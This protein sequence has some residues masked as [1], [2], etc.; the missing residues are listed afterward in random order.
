MGSAHAKCVGQLDTAVLTA[1]CD[2]DE[3]VCAEKSAEHSVPGFTEHTRLLDSGLVD[4]VLIATPHYFHPPIAIDAFERGIHVLSE[5]PIAVTV[6]A[7]DEMIA[8]ARKSGCKFA[9]MFQMRTEAV[10]IAAKRLIEEGALGE[11]YRTCCIMAWYRSQAYY[12][13]GGWRATWTGE[14]GGVLINQAP[15]LL[16]IFTWLAGLPSEIVAKVRTRLHDIEV[17]DEAFAVLTYAN[18][19]HG[20]LY[21]STTEAPGTGLLEISGECGKLRIQDGRLRFWRLDP[22][23]R[24]HSDETEEMWSEPKAEEVTV[25]LPDVESGHRAVTANFVDAIL[26]GTPLVTPGEEG[27]NAME[28][29]NGII[30]SGHTGRPVSV[31]V[32]RAEYCALIEKLKA[33]SRGKTRLREQRVTDPQHQK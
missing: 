27:L 6:S 9:V 1:V 28:M 11:I 33:S 17:E 4:A 3:S 15:H 30:L 25:E 23:R 21:T 2:I 18:G 31:P 32:D 16:D 13:S 12:D 10:N 29:I 5:K 7:A 19:A 24:V 14:G 26:H 22:P 8:A 20:Y